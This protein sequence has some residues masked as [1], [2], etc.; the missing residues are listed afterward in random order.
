[1]L[2]E[3]RRSIILSLLDERGT[4]SVSELVSELHASESTIRRDLITLN[5]A[6]SLKKVHGGAVKL[7]TGVI[8]T[9]PSVNDKRH[10]FPAEKERIARYAA[11]LIRR[12]D[13]VFIDAGT[14]TEK[15]IEYITEKDAIYITNAYNHARLLVKRGCKVYLAG[16]EMK[17]I[18]E[19]NVGVT[20]VEMLRGYNFTKCFLGTNG[21]SKEAGFSTHDIDE[22]SVK[23]IA[24]ERSYITYILADHSKFDKTATV[25]F[26]QISR[27]C[28]ITD[29]VK[30]DEY[31]SL[32]VVKEVLQ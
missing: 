5:R 30:N 7:E 17:D 18:T 26:A 16:G 6:G 27:A 12:G 15:M 23:R 22:A 1:M 29:C 20:C 19:A 8:L 9:E 3:E 14:T 28:I 31:R 32:T 13:L 24:A 4:L 11:G 10:L 2:T 21:I 25:N